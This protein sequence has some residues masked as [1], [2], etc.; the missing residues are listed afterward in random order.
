VDLL[1]ARHT[2][3]PLSLTTSP[4][5]TARS[6]R[7]IVTVHQDETANTQL[8]YA[9]LRSRPEPRET[10]P[11]GD[12]HYALVHTDT[13]P[14]E[15]KNETRCPR[16]QNLTLRTM[17]SLIFALRLNIIELP[18]LSATPGRKHRDVGSRGRRGT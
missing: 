16:G 9:P 18:L 17:R 15:T 4:P 11:S 13:A 6:P 8:R 2:P 3:V 5:A 14:D 1:I 10:R 7:D 12:V